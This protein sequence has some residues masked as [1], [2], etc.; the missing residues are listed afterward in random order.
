MSKQSSTPSTRM[1]APNVGQGQSYTLLETP[2]FRVEYPLNLGIEFLSAVVTVVR[3]P[4]TRASIDANPGAS[5]TL[6][7]ATLLDISF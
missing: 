5:G 3:S 6:L 7:D 4:A 1:I 2:E